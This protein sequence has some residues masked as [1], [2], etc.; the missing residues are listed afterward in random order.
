[1]SPISFILLT[2]NVRAEERLTPEDRIYTGELICCVE[3]YIYIYLY[4]QQDT[5]LEDDLEEMARND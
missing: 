4:T 3:G 5:F 2:C 1:M